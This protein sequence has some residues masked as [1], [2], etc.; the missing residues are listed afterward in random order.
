[1]QPADPL[2]EL[3]GGDR[4]RAEDDRP[5]PAEQQ[6]ARDD[7]DEGER[8]QPLAVDGDRHRPQLGEQR[9]DEEDGD[10]GRVAQPERKGRE[11]E[12]GRPG[13][14]G[15]TDRARQEDEAQ[16]PGRMV[17]GSRLQR[18]PGTGSRQAEPCYQRAPA[19]LAIA[20]ARSEPS[21]MATRT[22]GELQR[23]MSN[24]LR[25]EAAEQVGLAS[26]SAAG[27]A[28]APP[29]PR[30]SASRVHRPGDARGSYVPDQLASARSAADAC[31]GPELARYVSSAATTSGSNCFPACS[32]S[33]ATAASTEIA[34]R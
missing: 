18:P 14:Q 30:D 9:R 24:L 15:A 20:S 22:S 16:Q 31:G 11:R 25:F 10:S 26:V 6:L 33:S 29:V 12:D 17:L 2:R 21:A 3:G 23:I 5:L 1:A 19:P 32:R 13:R 4:R 28:P 8:D 7:E 34:R 27:S